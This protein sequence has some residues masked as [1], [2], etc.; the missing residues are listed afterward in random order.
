[1]VSDGLKRVMIRSIDQSGPSDDDLEMTQGPD[2]W[3]DMELGPCVDSN[4]RYAT[5]TEQGYGDRA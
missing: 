5:A 4:S 1:M 2:P 3:S